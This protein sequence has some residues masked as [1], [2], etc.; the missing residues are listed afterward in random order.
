MSGLAH[1]NVRTPA[2]ATAVT[3]SKPRASD[4]VLTTSLGN[5]RSL[6]LVKKEYYR[7]DLVPYTKHLQKTKFVW[8][9]DADIRRGALEEIHT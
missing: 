7:P 8:F 9:P 6:L 4:T 5:I 1:G 2:I 3:Y